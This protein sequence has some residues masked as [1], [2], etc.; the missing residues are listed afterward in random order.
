MILVFFIT[1]NNVQ[2]QISSLEH[3]PELDWYTI[4][5]EHFEIHYPREYEQLA[6]Q[7]SVICEEIYSPVSNSLNYYPKRTQVVIQT[8]VDFPSGVVSYLPWRMELFITEPQ[9]NISG[10]GDTWLRVVI[11]HEFTHIVQMQKRGKITSLT[12]PLL[13]DFNAFWQ[14]VAPIWFTEGFATFNETRYTSGGRGRGAYHLMQMLAPLKDGKPWP[15]GNTNYP[16]R[17]R[18]TSSNMPYLAGYYLS[19]YIDRE[20]GVQVWRKISDKYTAF[21]LLGFNRAVKSVTGKSIKRLY[22]E[23]LSEFEIQ[24]KMRKQLTPTVQYWRPTNNIENQFSPRWIDQNNLMIYRKSLDDLQELLIINRKKVQTRIKQR[25]LSK[26]EN[27]FTNGTNIIV[28]AELRPHPR[29]SATIYSDLFIFDKQ[30][31]KEYPLTKNARIY[32]PDLSPDETRVVAIQTSLPTTRLVTVTLK[33]GKINTLLDI[34]GATILNPRWSPDGNRIAFALKDSLGRQDIAVINIRTGQWKRIYPSDN[35]HDNNP[36]WTPDNR[37]VLF[38]SDRSGIFNIWAVDIRSGKRWMVTD[39][40][41]GAFTPDVSPTGNEL[42]FS[43]YTSQGLRI[44]TIPLDTTQWLDE[45]QVKSINHPMKF[46]PENGDNLPKPLIPQKTSEVSKYRPW[47]QILFPQAWVP[48][49]FKK[50]DN[51]TTGIF[52]ISKDALHRHSWQGNISFPYKETRPSIYFNYSYRRWWLVPDIRFFSTLEMVINNNN[53]NTGW[54]RKE[55]VDMGLQLPLI[56]ESN[57][58]RT[59]LRP[60][61][62]FKNQT[63]RHSTGPVYPLNNK[64]RGFQLGIDWGRKSQ[65]PRDIVPYKA[66]FISIFTDWSEPK[67]GSEFRGRQVSGSI[68][69]YYPTLI[70]HH[71]IELLSKFQHRQGNI[72][73]SYFN[74]L[75]IGYF[76]DNRN[77]QMRVKIAYIMPLSYL[78]YAI[79][80]LPVFVDYLRADLFYDWGKSWND[81]DGLKKQSHFTRY[82]AGIRILTSNYI[83]KRYTIRLGL[84]YYYHSTKKTWITAPIIEYYF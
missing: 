27:S 28:W 61:I 6:K 54:L 79:P 18:I 32:S 46:I 65:T 4:K 26:Q 13:G 49:F 50:E 67:L 5:T 21:P 37:F 10:S 80:I 20:Y 47:N 71:Q 44:V 12:Y 38:T 66:C 29:F 84:S 68:G 9:G 57:V 1:P 36:C 62:R 63:W 55:G 81:P 19:F 43:N 70:P 31:K 39:S 34:P 69:I 7:V 3:E 24:L 53:N 40:K 2:S 77:N 48:Y 82:S 59:Y 72:R 60:F 78:E 23:M 25:A 30:R 22:N 75:P 58:F 42:A 17:K 11:T 14:Q 64:Y 83:F 35:H 45:T 56:P 15:L 51:N 76:D 74:A 16:S 41:L 52:L 8:R 33:E 73:Y